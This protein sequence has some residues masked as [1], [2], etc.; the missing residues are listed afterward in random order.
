MLDYARE[1]GV[2]VRFG[3]NVVRYWEDGKTGR[4]GVAINGPADIGGSETMV[5]GDVIVGADGVRSFARDLVLVRFILVNSTFVQSFDR[6]H[7]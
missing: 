1:I 6:A 7:L 4:A 3:C 2:D 5:M